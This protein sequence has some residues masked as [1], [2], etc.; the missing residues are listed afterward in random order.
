MTFVERMIGA[1][2]LDCEAF[3]EVEADR[4]ATP[5]AMAVVVLAAVA[6]G[7]GVG[8]GLRGLVVGTLFGLLGWA[9]WAWLIYFIGTRWLPEPGTHADAGELLGPSASRP[10]PGILRVAGP[11]AR[12]RRPCDHCHRRVDA[13]GHDRGRPAGARLPVHR[14]GR[15]RV[16][17]RLGRADGPPPAGQ[18]PRAAPGSGRTGGMAVEALYA[19]QNGFMGAERSLLFYGEYSEARVQIPIACWLIRTTDGADPVR[20]RRVAAGGA[21][22]DAQRPPRALHRG[23]PARPSPRRPRPR[24]RRRRHRW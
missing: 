18:R 22:P 7:I 24:D 15:R 4:G 19:L 5:Q 21:R 8:A 9:V 20:H 17:H 1:A 23:R 6:G 2:K 13:G 10:R 3:E 11:R 16:S 14:P 12:A